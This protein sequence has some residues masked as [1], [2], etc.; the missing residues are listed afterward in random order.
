MRFKFFLFVILLWIP[1]AVPAK[2]MTPEEQASLEVYKSGKDLESKGQYQQALD[3]F[4]KAYAVYPNP[5]IHYHI[6]IC[7]YKLNDCK[8]ALPVL[9]RLLMQDIDPQYRAVIDQDRKS[10][11][12]NC[13]ARKAIATHGLDAL[14]IRMEMVGWSSR[15]KRLESLSLLR[16]LI[17]TQ[18]NGYIRSNRFK[19]TS[20]VVDW[21]KHNKA[22]NQ[23][24]LAR[25]QAGVARVW[26]ADCEKKGDWPCADKQYH[27]MKSAGDLLG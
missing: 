3:I 24:Q 5:Y 21:T 10:M 20:G 15:E 27:L 2:Q 18:V 8:N 11:V 1:V 17:R 6:G 4:K 25:L 14:K 22:M 9:K 12:F 13:L 19:N 23:I 16:E 26:A 7:H